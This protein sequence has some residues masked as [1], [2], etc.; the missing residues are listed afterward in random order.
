MDKPIW[1]PLRLD[2]NSRNRILDSL[3]NYFAVA[4]DI[5]TA[6]LLVLTMNEHV[7]HDFA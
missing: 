2:I 6:A 1:Y 5:E 4:K 7:R 3:G